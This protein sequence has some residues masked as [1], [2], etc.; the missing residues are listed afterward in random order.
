M[1]YPSRIKWKPCLLKT[2][3]WKRLLEMLKQC[4]TTWKKKPIWLRFHSINC[5]F[6]AQYWQC[7][8]MFKCFV[9]HLY[10]H[11]SRKEIVNMLYPTEENKRDWGAVICCNEK[12][13]KIHQGERESKDRHCTAWVSPW[14]FKYKVFNNLRDSFSPC[15]CK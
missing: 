9:W 7:I 1:L 3:Y 12:R 10:I 14:M 5:I 15:L 2:F 13:W 4:K 11:E 8:F 6:L